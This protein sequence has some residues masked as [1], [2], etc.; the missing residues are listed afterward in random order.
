MTPEEFKIAKEG[1]ESYLEYDEA[2]TVLCDRCLET[3][4]KLVGIVGTHPEWREF[5]QA[6]F[7]AIEKVSKMGRERSLKMLAAADK[8]KEEVE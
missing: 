4:K 2:I 7:D 3:T 8:L 5:I 1:I 6:N